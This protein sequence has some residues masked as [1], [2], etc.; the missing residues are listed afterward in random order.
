MITWFI[1]FKE[2]QLYVVYSTT[3]D[4][5]R[6]KKWNMFKKRIGGELQ[7]N[8]KENNTKKYKNVD[9]SNMKKNFLEL[10]NL[11]EHVYLF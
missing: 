5:Y 11:F 10:K 1:D 9:S 2:K 3:E 7:V 6:H 8:K 4:R